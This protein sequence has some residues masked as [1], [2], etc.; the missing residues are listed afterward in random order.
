[1]NCAIRAS[2]ENGVLE[3]ADHS[4]YFPAFVKRHMQNILHIKKTGE[5]FFREG[6]AKASQYPAVILM[7]LS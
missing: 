7:E 5:M 3:H 2:L 1:V 4:A 6:P